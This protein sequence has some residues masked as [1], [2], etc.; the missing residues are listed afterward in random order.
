MKKIAVNS[1]LACS[2]LLSASIIVPLKALAAFQPIK[3]GDK[4][5]QVYEVEK[6]LNK[7]GYLVKADQSFEDETWYAVA[8]FQYKAKLPY[9]GIVDQT[10][11]NALKD[12]NNGKAYQPKQPSAPAAKPAPT[13]KPAPVPG[14]S[15]TPSNGNASEE[16]AKSNELSVDEQ[17][18]FALINQ[19]RKKAGLKPLA[20]D[21]EAAKVARIKAN[22]MIDKNY[23]SHYSPTYGSPFKMLRSFG[24]SYRMAGENIAGNWSIDDAHQ[25]LMNS[26]GH[27]MNIMN[28]AYTHVGI[29]IVNGGPYGKMFVQI[30]IGK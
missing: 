29:G 8:R 18:M 26:S 5:N 28:S 24:V 4:G 7:L 16:Y 14:K 9:N 30:F 15:Q 23:F 2:L 20:N 12:A 27:R 11:Y 3:Q 10:T 25:R 13:V 17:K 21:A 6:M 1:L 19:E 22:E